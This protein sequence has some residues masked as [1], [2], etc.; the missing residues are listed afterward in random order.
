MATKI[1]YSHAMKD[2]DTQ[3]ELDNMN[4]IRDKY[5]DAI[6]FNPKEL[7]KGDNY[8]TP[9]NYSEFMKDLEENCYPKIDECDIFVVSKYKHGKYT[10]GV[11]KELEYA[12]FLGKRILDFD[13]PYPLVN[14]KTAINKYERMKFYAESGVKEFIDDFFDVKK[15]VRCINCHEEDMY[16]LKREPVYR[17]WE[18]GKCRAYTL[19]DV[20]TGKYDA[21]RDY[22]CAHSYI[23][24]FDEYALRWNNANESK[25]MF[26]EHRV[27]INP[28]IELD[29][30]DDPG[31]D[32]AKRLSF[33]DYV[34]E[35]DNAIE[36]VISVLKEL[37]TEATK[38]T[39]I[40]YDV[41]YNLQF[42]GNGIYIYLEG[43]YADTILEKGGFVS[44]FINILDRLK[45]K[46]GLGDPMKVH[47]CNAKAPWNDYFKIP[48]TF[49]ETRPRIS[50]PLMKGKLDGE[51]IDRVSDIN[52]IMNDYSI[53]KEIVEKAKWVKIW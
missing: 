49:H 30:P 31:S 26:T 10:T 17:L 37:T 39:G 22:Q 4:A 23:Y 9:K 45:E 7:L 48:F 43:S 3:F 28:L 44:N 52:N 38:I 6:I 53:V 51:W 40:E 27:G 13:L 32:K 47:V 33:F 46:E 5:P 8:I 11:K 16:K 36:K 29:A 12:K 41:E 35:F 19:P 15:G 1:Y 25:S 18:N 50:I 2:Y 24:I 20:I 34:K 42:S 21:L 14:R